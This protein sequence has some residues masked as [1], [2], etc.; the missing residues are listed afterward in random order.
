MSLSEKMASA[1]NWSAFMKADDLKRRLKFTLLMLIVYRIGSYIPLPLIDPSVIRELFSANSGLLGMFDM[2][3][4]GSLSRMTLFALNIMPY[5]SASIIIQL[6]SAIIPS[7]KALKKE[8]EA[9]HRKVTQYTRYLTVLITVI[10]GYSISIGLEAM[11]A[12]LHPGWFFRLTTVVSLLGGTMFVVW[13]GEQITQR[14]IGN[15]SSMIITTGIVAGIPSAIG[16]T[17]EL[18]RVGSLSAFKILLIVAAIGAMVSLII[19]FERAMRKVPIQ[20]PKRQVNGRAMNASISYMPLKINATGVIPPI[21]ASSLLLMPITILNF[22]IKGETPSEFL[23]TLT[24]YFSHGHPVY[25]TVFAALIIFFSFFYTA[26]VFNPEETADNLK[27]Q[28]GFIAGIRPGKSTADYFDYV[29]T[30]LTVLGAL[31]LVVVCIAP[32]LLISRLSVPFF[33]GGTTLMIVVSVTLEFVNQVQSHLIA[34]QYEG[35]IK[36]AKSKGL[37]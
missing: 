31:F 5:I 35:L 24:V 21:F 14:G 13:L 1:S 9:G 12:S 29:I 28:G 17:L 34:H 7:L 25:L 6:A 20:Y 10:Q 36:K 11:G 16:R 22:A 4:G 37:F 19:F 23:Q 2:F 26:I 32:E 18:A 3:A 30:R 27:K 33:F 8:G 15:G